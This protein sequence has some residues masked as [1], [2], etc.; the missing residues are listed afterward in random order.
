MSHARQQIREAFATVV[1]GLASTGS[2]VFQS[3]MRAQETLPC[4]LVVTNDETI[5]PADFDNKLE[6]SLAIVVS[7][8]A[9]AAANVDDTLDTIALEVETAVGSLNYLGGKVKGLSLESITTEFDDSL[10]QPV[11]LINL[12]YRCTYYTNAGV[13]GTTV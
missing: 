10:Q 6:H 12:G 13:P 11:G 4:L 5:V 1:T 8:V 9:Q 3:R 7:G 2:R